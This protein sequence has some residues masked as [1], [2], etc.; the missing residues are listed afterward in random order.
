MIHPESKDK[1]LR[2][3]VQLPSDLDSAEG[4]P[5]YSISGFIVNIVMA[6]IWALVFALSSYVIF[7]D[8][9]DV[10]MFFIPLFITS[11][12]MLSFHLYA[13]FNP[14]YGNEKDEHQDLTYVEILK[15]HWAVILG[16]TLVLLTFGFLGCFFSLDPIKKRNYRA[17]GE[18]FLIL[19]AIYAVTG[20]ICWGFVTNNRKNILARIV[21]PW[22]IHENTENEAV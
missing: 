18:L 17:L 22:K 3:P 11:L 13:L 8:P 19:S 6:L 20:M 21:R 12:T 9:D 15:K 1:N 4:K 7:V 10:I 2:E 5:Q 16:T 14:D